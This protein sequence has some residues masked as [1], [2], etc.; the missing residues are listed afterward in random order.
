[1]RQGS[2]GNWL[3]SIS[4]WV[5]WAMYLHLLWVLFVLAG[6]VVFGLA[7]ATAALFSVVRK[8]IMHETDMP[9]FKTFVNTFKSTFLETNLLGGVYLFIGVF[10]YF[11]LHISLTQIESFFLHLFLI[12]LCCIYIITVLFSIP[13]YVHYRLRKF[14]YLKQAFLIALARPLEALAMVVSLLVLFYIF[15]FIPVFLFFVGS[16]IVS[17]LLMWIGIHAFEKIEQKAR[18]NIP[19][20]ERS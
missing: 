6:L 18:I 1:M 19:Y 20:K 11:D 15:R 13:V 10:L 16:T 5:A 9:I 4:Q 7:P 17:Y 2:L 14:S 12:L 3:Y 8:W